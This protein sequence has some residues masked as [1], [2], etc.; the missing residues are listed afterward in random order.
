MQQEETVQNKIQQLQ[1][2]FYAQNPKRTFFKESQKIQCSEHIAQQLNIE[3]LLQKSFYIN[4]NTNNIVCDYTIFKTFANANNYEIMINYVMNLVNQ[5]ITQYSTFELHVN[6]KS[7]TITAAQRHMDV[8]RHF[9]EKCL[10]KD[11][12]YCNQLQTLYLYNCPSMI[13]TVQRLFSGFMDK[14]SLLK[15]VLRNENI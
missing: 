2:Q 10:N 8:I 6:L 4:E 11:S 9:C 13:Q 15:V 3:M 5:C 12:L 1:E 14:D 7:F